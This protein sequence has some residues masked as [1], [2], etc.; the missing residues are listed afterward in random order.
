MPA[1]NGLS[2][3][4]TEGKRFERSGRRL[5]NFIIGKR[6]YEMLYLS[7]IRD[8]IGTMG[9]T[10]D[11]KVYSGKMPDKNFKSIGVYN[12]KRSRPPNIP[13]GGLKNSSYGVRSVSLLC[14]WNKS[15]RETERAAQRL[16]NELYSTRNSVINGNRI[17]FVMLLLDEPV[18]VDTDENGIYEYVIECDFYY[19]RKE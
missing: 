8:F 6:G 3:T 16:W 9:I 13:V 4:R 5:S 2:L 1:E 11:E 12:L 14:H 7:D 18:S 10:D 17:L 15:Q 19:E